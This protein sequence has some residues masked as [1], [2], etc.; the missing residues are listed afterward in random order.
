ME[1]FDDNMLNILS[2]NDDNNDNVNESNID[3]SD[4]S[5]NENLQS[6]WKTTVERW[7]DLTLDETIETYDSPTVIDSQNQPIHPADDPTAKWLLVDLFPGGLE[8]PLYIN[9][10]IL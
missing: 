10:Q 2:D 9:E 1:N 3:N 8:A 5:D 4:D 6:F 7:I